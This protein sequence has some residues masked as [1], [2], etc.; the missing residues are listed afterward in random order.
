MKKQL[1]Y[2]ILFLS[3]AALFVLPVNCF[4]QITVESRTDTLYEGLGLKGILDYEIFKRALEGMDEYEFEKTHLL[5]IIDYTKASHRKRMF[6]I[7]LENEKLLYHTLVAHGKNSGINYAEDFSNKN[8]SLKSSPG[9]YKTAETY[10]GKHG[11]SLKLDGLEEGINDHA[12]E[13]L[14]VIHGADYVSQ[15]FIDRHGRIGRSWGC[16]ALPLPLTK[17]VIT[18]IKEGSCLYIH[19]DYKSYLE[20]STP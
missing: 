12:R 9:F 8:R 2:L 15:D 3:F 5:T 13:R 18:L 10:F 7:D 17:E 6:V 20:Q 4:G 16:P 14:I 1:K 11:Y 19:T